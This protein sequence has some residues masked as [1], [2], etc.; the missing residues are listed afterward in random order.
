M[1]LSHRGLDSFGF[2]RLVG[3]GFAVWPIIEFAR[4]AVTDQL[5]V[6]SQV[7]SLGK[8]A[9]RI[10]ISALLSAL[11]LVLLRR[12]P[13][14]PDQVIINVQNVLKKLGYFTG[15]VNGFLGVKTRRALTAYEQD[16]G[17][18]ATRHLLFAGQASSGGDSASSA[19]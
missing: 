1:V 16:Y 6:L 12:G 5:A 3:M 7:D 18:D 15:D 9:A 2:W 14:V 8:V 4:L 10:V 13:P 19:S 11:L 17:L